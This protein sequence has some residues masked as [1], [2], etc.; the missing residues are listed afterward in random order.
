MSV[1]Q[2]IYMSAPF[3]FDDAMLNGI[4]SQARRNNARSD[5]TGCLICRHDLYLQILEGDEA[6]VEALFAKI[7]VDDR[8]LAVARLSATMADARMFP[9]WSMRDDPAQ[10]WVWSPA[11][12]AKGVPQ[13]ATVEALQAVF[14]R[15][16]A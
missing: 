8:H 6:P 2:L 10:S 3:G 9:H 16:A 15:V 11:E 7:A 12:I 5:I 1:F 13:A 4:L 14:A